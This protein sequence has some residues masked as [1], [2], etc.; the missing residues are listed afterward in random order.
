MIRNTF[1]AL[2]LGLVVICV[3]SLAANVM[4]W[5]ENAALSRILSEHENDL[6]LSQFKCRQMLSD[7][8]SSDQKRLETWRLLLSHYIDRVS[9]PQPRNLDELAALYRSK[10][11]GGRSNYFA[12]L[13]FNLSVASS[14]TKVSLV[15]YLGSPDETQVTP[16]G[17]FLLYRYK[18]NGRDASAF[19]IVSNNI[20]VD[21]GLMGK[22]VS[23]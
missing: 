11:S 16:K 20:V 6:S 3:I 19:F 18:V 10:D 14:L 7:L 4:L 9:S 13:V 8:E 23:N 2:Q 17:Q 5:R 21:T 15:H 12:E 22:N 1:V